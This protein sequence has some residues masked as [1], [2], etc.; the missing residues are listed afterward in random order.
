[1]VGPVSQMCNCS[2]VDNADDIDVW[3]DERVAHILFTA[4]FRL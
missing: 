3:I 2:G 4:V 1:M